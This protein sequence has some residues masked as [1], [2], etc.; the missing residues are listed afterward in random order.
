MQMTAKRQSSKVNA[1]AGGTSRV[2]LGSDLTRVDAT[3]HLALGPASGGYAEQAV[4]DCSRHGHG[5]RP[6]FCSITSEGLFDYSELLL[7]SLILGR[8]VWSSTSDM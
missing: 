2:Y 3:T 7:L 1:D 8:I 5:Y 6:V 4:I